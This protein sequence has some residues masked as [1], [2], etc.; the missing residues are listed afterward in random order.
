LFALGYYQ[1][2]ASLRAG[3]KTNQND[4]ENNNE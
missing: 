4:K 1:Q 3:K 2:L